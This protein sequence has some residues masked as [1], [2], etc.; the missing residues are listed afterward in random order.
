[1]APKRR[2]YATAAFW[3]FAGTMHFVRPKMY[4]EIVPRQLERWKREV[5]IASG[6]AE[7]AGGI[8]AIPESTRRGA[9]WWLLAT[10]VAIYPANIQM[11]LNPERYSRIPR[12]LLWARLPFQGVFAWLIWRGT[13]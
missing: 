12:P 9:R 8:A 11:A 7:L 6:V 4:D 3:I 10:L 1:M 2:R 5:T 13:E